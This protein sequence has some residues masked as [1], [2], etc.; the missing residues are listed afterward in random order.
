[1]IVTTA[2]RRSHSASTP[3]NATQAPSIAPVLVACI[4]G[5]GL[6]G[7]GIGSWA[8]ARDVLRGNAPYAPSPTVI[9][10][11]DALP[12]VER[13][14]AGKAVRIALAAGLEASANAGRE[15]A[16]MSA[17]FTSSTGDGENIHAICEMLASSDRLISPTRFHNSVHNAPSGYWGI[18]TGSQRPADSL[19]AFDASFAA[20]LVEAMTRLATEP[21][22]PVLL[23]AYDAPYPEPLN[24]VRRIPDAFAVALALAAPHATA[25]RISIA[26]DAGD[27][28]GDALDDPHLEQLRCAIPAARSLPLLR[29]VARAVEG[30]VTLDY[31]DG[32]ALRVRC[33]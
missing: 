4:E 13:R 8:A 9:P 17:V 20:G 2:L 29:L 32:L 31:L 24:A 23:V 18:A 14:R 19:A 11:P 3:R 7:P 28:R 22:Q 12:A 21:T 15:P 16:G 10:S 26:L 27:A 5:V 1:M 33:S 30:S 25:H 6:V